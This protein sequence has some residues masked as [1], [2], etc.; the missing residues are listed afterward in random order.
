MAG[1]LAAAAAVS[2]RCAGAAGAASPGGSTSAGGS[3]PGGFT[4]ASSSGAS[5]PVAGFGG[6]IASA[7]A[8]PP[9]LPG[10]GSGTGPGGATLL[11]SSA[12]EDRVEELVQ[13]GRT[14]RDALRQVARENMGAEVRE[15]LQ[16]TFQSGSLPGCARACGAICGA[17]LVLLFVSAL[18]LCAG[19]CTC[20]GIL[21]LSGW[22]FTWWLLGCGHQQELRIWLLVYQASSLAEA[23]VGTL[24]RGCA[25]KV[26]EA[27]DSR[28][29]PGFARACALAYSALSFGLKV[30]WCVHVQVL[31]AEHTRSHQQ[32][33]HHHSEGGDSSKHHEGEHHHGQGA[34]EEECGHWLPRFMGWY[35]C[36]LLLQLLVVE[37]ALRAGMGL[38]L[39]AATRGLLQTTRGAKPGTLDDMQNVDFDEELFAKA[40]DPSDDR[41]QRE[42]CFCLEEYDEHSAIIRTPC[43]HMMH[44][45]CLAKWLQTSHYCP[46]CRG[47]LEDEPREEDLEAPLVMH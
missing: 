42:C 1:P 36:I 15:G 11:A 5:S 27:L 22:F 21:H 47:N 43:R 10:D 6:G 7:T 23:F 34:V 26:A 3:S 33:Q 46:I 28:V 40:D 38:A 8:M 19:V 12:P 32:Q 17:L 13:S 20:C 35:S 4:L 45:E 25:Q 14:R 9:P 30:L 31:V 37:P 16:D 24:A 2:L 39:T 29:R 41:P 44:R 18:L